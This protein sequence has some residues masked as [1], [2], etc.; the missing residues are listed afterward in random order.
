M[1][2]LSPR[3]AMEWIEGNI[4]DGKKGIGLRKIDRE[5]CPT[6]HAKHQ[7]T[8]KTQPKCLHRKTFEK[9]AVTRRPK[10]FN[11]KLVL[12]I[13]VRHADGLGVSVDK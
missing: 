8:G 1:L 7:A 9:R 2:K 12:P 4:G 11:W 10:N 5:T 3:Q 13:C 6:K